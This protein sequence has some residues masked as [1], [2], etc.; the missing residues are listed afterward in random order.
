M[1]PPSQ[2]HLIIDYL[3]RHG[4][5]STSRLQKELPLSYPKLKELLA[6]LFGKGVIGC[7]ET[8]ERYAVVDATLKARYWYLKEME[9]EVLRWLGQNSRILRLRKLEP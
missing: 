1:Y 4:I 9:E 6:Y 3:A 5:A 7:V 2:V 8:E